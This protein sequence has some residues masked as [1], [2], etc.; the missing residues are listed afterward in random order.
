MAFSSQGPNKERRRACAV[1]PLHDL[2]S[3]G[4]DGKVRGF[5]Y[6]QDCSA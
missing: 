1:S 5:R 2:A 3:P 4:H 6:F